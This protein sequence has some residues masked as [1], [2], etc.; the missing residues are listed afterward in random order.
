MP[1]SPILDR[2]L[3]VERLSD[4]SLKLLDFAL[5]NT[6]LGGGIEPRAH[7]RCPQP[8]VTGPDIGGGDAKFEESFN[9]VSEIRDNGSIEALQLTSGLNTPKDW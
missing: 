5:V 3:F 8:S 4:G 1:R 9:R 7:A 2:E 6:T